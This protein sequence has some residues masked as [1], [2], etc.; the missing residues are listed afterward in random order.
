P[1]S[2]PSGAWSPGPATCGRRSP[3]TT[4]TDRSVAAPAVATPSASRALQR[5]ALA[6]ALALGDRPPHLPESVHDLL[7]TALRDHVLVGL[8]PG[9]VHRLAEHLPCLPGRGARHLERRPVRVAVLLEAQHVAGRNE[10]R[11][12]R[13]GH[14]AVAAGQSALALAGRRVEALL[15]AAFG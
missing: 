5:H 9:P 14:G 8:C 10:E 11:R 7:T 15:V 12:D 13:V 2:R 4:S 1:S 3:R 6:H